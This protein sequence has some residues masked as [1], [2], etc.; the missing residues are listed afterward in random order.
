MKMLFMGYLFYCVFSVS[1]ILFFWYS[2]TLD[3]T[4]QFASVI[5]NYS[6]R[7]AVFGLFSK[8]KSTCNK[9]VLLAGLAG[10]EPTGDGVKVRC[11]TAW[12]QPNIYITLELYH[13]GKFMSINK[14]L[15]ICKKLQPI[16]SFN[17]FKFFAN[18][19]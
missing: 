14:I 13:I 18:W 5:I 6:N 11:L 8:E 16:F 10:F 7:Y 9:Q 17:S 2:L 19:F 12:R 1:I 3:V 4:K 15:I